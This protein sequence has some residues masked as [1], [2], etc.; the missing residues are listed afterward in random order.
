MLNENFNQFGRHLFLQD[1][2]ADN[3]RRQL[4]PFYTTDISIFEWSCT[5]ATFYKA[6]PPGFASSPPSVKFLS[7]R[8]TIEANT[9]RIWAQYSG[10]RNG[11]HNIEEE[12]RT[13]AELENKQ[14]HNA[15]IRKGGNREGDHHWRTRM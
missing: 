1:G 2:P 5:V 9:I 11:K 6:H 7:T 12:L 10:W 8:P 3:Q 4:F 15:T 14:M 13:D